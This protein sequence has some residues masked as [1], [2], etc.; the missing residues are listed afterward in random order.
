MKTAK[1]ELC[2]LKWINAEMKSLRCKTENFTD[3]FTSQPIQS[4]VLEWDLVRTMVTPPNH[5]KTISFLFQTILS[6]KIWY[7]TD[8]KQE[9]DE[10]EQGGQL[11]SECSDT[12]T[13]R[14]I[15]GLRW[16]HSCFMDQKNLTL[17]QGT[18][19]ILKLHNE[20]TELQ[21]FWV[22]LKWVV[23]KWSVHWDLLQAITSNYSIQ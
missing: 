12:K 4:A 7:T 14:I 1:A 9:D 15:Y 10:D 6:Y 5:I 18:L 16:I 21:P 3:H 17:V 2:Q 23:S 22:N 8:T 13:D 11:D 19:F 20:A